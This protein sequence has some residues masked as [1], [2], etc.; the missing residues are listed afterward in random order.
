MAETELLP[1]AGMSMLGIQIASDAADTVARV[2]GI[3]GLPRAN[4]FVVAGDSVVVWLGPAELLV[5]GARAGLEAE[6][7]EAIGE[8][9]GAVVDLSAAR[10]GLELRGTQAREVL[11]TCAAIDLHPRAFSPG[12]AAVTLVARVPVVLFQVDDTPS[13]RLLA[14]PTLQPFLKDWLEEGL[15]SGRGED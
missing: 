2:L 10:V 12:S 11:S 13:F 8:D 14:P 4:R 7:R 15:P 9:R 6:L 5:V 3:G 1:L